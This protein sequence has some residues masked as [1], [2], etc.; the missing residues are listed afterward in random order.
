MLASMSETRF[1]VSLIAYGMPDARG[2]AGAAKAQG[3][4]S[5]R[6]EGAF[7]LAI[8]SLEITAPDVT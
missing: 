8:S 2:Q 1:P 7:A 4:P 3:I 5:L 6:N